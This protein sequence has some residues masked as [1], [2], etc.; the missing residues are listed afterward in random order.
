MKKQRVLLRVREFK[1]KETKFNDVSIL[2]LKP[3]REDWIE[4]N[5]SIKEGEDVHDR[6]HEL[7]DK[8]LGELVRDRRDIFVEIEAS[9]PGLTVKVGGG[10]YT[11]RIIALSPRP[12][13][14]LRIGII[15]E[16][17]EQSGSSQE[18]NSSNSS[19]SQGFKLPI[20]KAKWYDV[21]EDLYLFEGF[22]LSK[23]QWKAIIFVTE[24]GERVLLPGDF[25]TKTIVIEESVKEKK[26]SLKPKTK[27]K[28]KKRKRKTKKKR[29]S[30]KKKG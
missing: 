26:K 12:S 23:K 28:K 17:N 2:L 8:K 1:P 7:L 16:E 13:K 10:D 14:L 15:V 9:M 11:G 25:E 27:S 6:L 30:R 4:E 18:L 21:E 24:Y 5:I 20:D 29:K 3:V 22:V 19:I